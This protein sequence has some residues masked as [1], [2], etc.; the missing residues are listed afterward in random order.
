MALADPRMTPWVQLSI[1]L[2]DHP[3]HGAALLTDTLE[4]LHQS[5]A[6]WVLPRMFWV[7]GRQFTN[8]DHQLCPTST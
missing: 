5:L 8:P 1:H 4:R 3:Y 7:A 2:D 6:S